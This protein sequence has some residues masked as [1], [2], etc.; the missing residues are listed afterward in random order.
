MCQQ[1]FSDY[2]QLDCQRIHAFADLGLIGNLFSRKP[3]IALYADRLRFE[4]FALRNNVMNQNK[5]R[6][7]GSQS[8]QGKT[9]FE[10]QQKGAQKGQAA[11]CLSAFASIFARF[12]T[13]KHG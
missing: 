8:T 11:F 7:A 9:N 13:F 1:F 4:I 6:T 12:L 10:N 2:R 5:K 3:L